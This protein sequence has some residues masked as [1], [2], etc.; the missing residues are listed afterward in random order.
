MQFAAVQRILGLLLSIFSFTMLPPLLMSWWL[1]DGATRSFLSGFV[2]IL[3]T[4]LLLWLP[5]HWAR[6]ELR[7]RDGFVVVLMFWVVLSLCGAVPFVLAEHPHMSVTDSA[8]E[9]VSGLTTTGATVITDIDQL[10]ASILFYRQLLQWLGGMGIIVLAVAILPILGIGGM[11]LYRAETPGPMKD[12]KLTPRI[13][14]TAKALWYIY[15]GL[16]VLCALAYWL[17]GM[18]GFDAI[19]HSFSTVSIGGFS[20]HDASHGYFNSPFVE[21]VAVVFMVLS[22]MNFA[23]HFTAWR[24]FSIL[25]YA[26]DAEL[27]TYL[28]LLSMIAIITSTYLYASDSFPTL[29]SAIRHG[30]FQT[31]SIST[32]TGFITTG[33]DT[34]PTF[35]PVLLLFS[36]FIGGCAGSTGGGLKVIRVLLLFKQGMREITRLIHPNAQLPIKIGHTILPYRVVDAIWGFFGTYVVAFALMLLLLMAT[37]LDQVT[38]FSAVAACINNLGPG[39]GEVSAHYGGLSATAKWILCVAMVLGRLEIFTLLVFLSPSFWRA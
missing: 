8:F 38:A 17:A 25:P 1:A 22:G 23:L 34:W 35:L 15:L 7:L 28:S 37:G 29:A 30:V 32:T 20:T 2:L 19:A 18:D 10:P 5:V 3:T 36:S 6:R 13:T 33:Y 4:G 14:E 9:A 12:S 21:A 24:S 27:K 31:V 39:L 16:T 26:H 11:Q